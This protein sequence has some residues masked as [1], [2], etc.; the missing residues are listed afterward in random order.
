MANKFNL[1][2]ARTR[3]AQ[4]AVMSPAEFMALVAGWNAG[5]VLLFLVS[6]LARYLSYGHDA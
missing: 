4:H 1:A 6:V 2:T 5:L 3:R